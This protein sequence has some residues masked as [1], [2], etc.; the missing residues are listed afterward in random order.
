MSCCCYWYLLYLSRLGLQSSIIVQ[1]RNQPITSSVYRT[2]QLK[3]GHFMSLLWA[4][5]DLSMNTLALLYGL[6]KLA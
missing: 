6:T 5:T 2:A 4:S 3:A 1:I